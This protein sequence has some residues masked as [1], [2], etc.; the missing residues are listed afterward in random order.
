MNNPNN[1]KGRVAQPEGAPIAYDETTPIVCDKCGCETY[2]Q[3]F[4]IRKV[5]ALISP[6]GIEGKLPVPLFACTKCGHINEEFL[7]DPGQT[8]N[9]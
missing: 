7:P 4:K 2:N 8:R 6:S 5:S 3:V 9:I 1:P